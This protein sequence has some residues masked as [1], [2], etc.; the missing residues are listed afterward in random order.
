MPMFPMGV[1]RFSRHISCRNQML[2]DEYELAL[3]YE[4]LESKLAFV[5]GLIK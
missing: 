1:S 2:D 4:E 3:R 5:S